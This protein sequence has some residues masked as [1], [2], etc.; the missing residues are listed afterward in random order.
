[1]RRP[2]NKPLKISNQRPKGNNYMLKL[3]EVLKSIA[4]QSGVSETEFKSILDNPALASIEVDDAVSTKLVAPRLSMDA[5][6]NNPDLKKHFTALALNGIDA[7]LERLAT[8]NGLSVEE[9]TELKGLESTAKRIETI[10]SKIKTLEAAKS[11]KGADTEK[12]TKE[13]E[14][15]NA[16][17]LTERNN[18][19]A[20]LQEKDNSLEVERI[21]WT[22]DTMLSNFDYSTPVDKEINVTLGKSLFNKSISEKGLK[23]VRKDNALSLQTAEGTEYFDN[24]V[25]VGINDYMTKV[26]ANA[27]VLKASN[28]TPAVKTPQQRTSTTQTGNGFANADAVIAEL[29]AKG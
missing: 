7:G 14:T 2:F 6:K 18:T 29:E 20:K 3:A 23:V 28:S 8:D 17:I 11:N 26:L 25:K 9:I 13:I 21:N 12:L 15:L 24:N 1:M 22:L 10:T 27:K 16:N 19:I 4:L 5:A